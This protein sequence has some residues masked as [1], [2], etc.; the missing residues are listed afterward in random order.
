MKDPKEPRWFQLGDALMWP[1]VGMS[2][3]SLSKRSSNPD[4][5]LVRQASGCHLAGCL[6]TSCVANE[7]G[8]HSVAIAL[9]RQALEALTLIDLGLHPSTFSDPVLDRWKSGRISHGEIRAHLEKEVWHSY[10]HGLWAEPW[11]EF[12]GN[13]AR[14]VQP[15]AHYTPE[16]QGWQDQVIEQHGEREATITVG[17]L[18]YDPLK[19]S[20]V[21][22]LHMLLAWA[23]GR[24]LLVHRDNPDVLAREAEI[25]LLGE[26]LSQSKLLIKNQKW[27]VQLLPH[28]WFRPGV[29][30]RGE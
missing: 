27:G 23:L 24:I 30:W 4:L 6:E 15:Y 26:S 20:R 7:R 17:L 22:L 28:M 12:F 10:G 8:K 5:A 25:H 29:N 11:S 2:L 1:L 13:L 19:A 9:V 3:A 21:T 14:A 16:L 18:T